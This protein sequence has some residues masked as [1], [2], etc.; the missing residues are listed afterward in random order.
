MSLDPSRIVILS[1]PSGVGKDSVLD[2]WMER[3]PR[4]ERVVAATTRNPRDGELDGDSYHFMS[5]DGFHDAAAAGRFLEF[6]EV[7]GNWYATPWSG[8]EAIQDRGGIAVLKIDV[9]GALEVL[10]EHPVIVSVFLLPP[11]MDELEKRI[12]GRKTD[13]E[14]T[15]ERRLENAREEIL[16]SQFYRFR[17]VNNDIERVVDELESLVLA[18]EKK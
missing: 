6:K 4:V 7:H 12:R 14:A 16:N 17:L 10:K 11:D 15:I 1:G 13:D 5:L 8:I 2:R 3:D 9:Q 18:T